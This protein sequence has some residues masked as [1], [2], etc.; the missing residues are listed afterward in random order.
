MGFKHFFFFFNA[1]GVCGD[2]KFREV[3]GPYSL[4]RSNLEYCVVATFS[5]EICLKLKEK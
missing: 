2:Q 3:N 1:G 5:K 4:E